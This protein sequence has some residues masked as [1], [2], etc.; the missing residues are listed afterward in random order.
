MKIVNK[1]ACAGALLLLILTGCESTGSIQGV[2][3]GGSN[4]SFE[5]TQ[6]IFAND[7]KLTVNMPDGEVF[8][9][10][11]VQQ[12]SS[13]SGSTWS[14]GES[15]NDDAFLLGD[16]TT[17][18]SK[19]QAL[20]IGNRGNSMKCQFQFSDPSFGI[21]GGGIGSCKISDGREINL[22]F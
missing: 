13:K 22:V 3:T 8:N 9:G 19:T 6:D 10:K 18:S 21:D 5:Y 15:S 11:F 20:L 1:S 2:S 17:T 4:V 14:I 12:S 16:S 7:G